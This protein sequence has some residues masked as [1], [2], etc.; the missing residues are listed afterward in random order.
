M[1]DHHYGKNAAHP[2]AT[3]TPDGPGTAYT[4][5][6]F[7]GIYGTHQRVQIPVEIGVVIHRPESDSLSFAGTA[8]KR[9][10]DVERWKNITDDVGRRVEGQRRVFNLAFRG[11]TKNFDKRFH[12]D[13]EAQA[14]A[15]RAVAG[16]HHDL[17]KFIRALNHQEISTLVFFARRREMETF[18]VSRIKTDRFFIR[19]LQDEIRTHFHLREHVSL[20]RASIVTKFRITKSAIQSAHFSYTLPERFRFLV[21]PHSAIGDACRIFLADLEFHRFP[22]EFGEVLAGH[23]EEYGNRNMKKSSPDGGNGQL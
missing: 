14:E 12:L 10:I 3:S 22:E 19:D 23:L 17:W 9:T 2:P 4:D 8:F 15:R 5:M 21:K 18:R 1:R 20:D 11:H 16:V 13:E 7:A 6:E